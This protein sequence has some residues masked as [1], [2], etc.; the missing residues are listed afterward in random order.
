[1]DE[2]EKEEF[3]D[4]L[5]KNSIVPNSG[6]IRRNIIIGAIILFIFLIILI[7]VIIFL[8]L[9]KSENL[10]VIGEINCKYDI[11]KINEEINILGDDFTKTSKFNIFVDGKKMNF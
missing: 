11:K 7:T 3:S 5:D 10:E 9:S 4:F 6:N 8:L 2:N 1:M